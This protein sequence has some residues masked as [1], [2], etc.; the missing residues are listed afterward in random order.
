MK[1]EEIKRLKEAGFS[2]FVSVDRLNNGSKSLIPDAKGVYVV[3]YKQVEGVPEFLEMGSGP[4][5]HGLTPMNYSV[6]ELEN[7]W[8]GDTSVV[9]I[10]KTDSSL[11]KRIGTFLRFGQ[12][13]NA[14]HRGGRSIWQLPYNRNLTF[15]WK[16]LP[17]YESAREKEKE[18]L[19][20]FKMEHG[21]RRPFANKVD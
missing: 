2:G 5:Y 8:V 11:K 18:M 3:L 13:H 19:D 9:Y 21:F 1:Q 17:A 7:E 6:A 4:E 10:G 15:A 12:G 14:S 20:K 16:V